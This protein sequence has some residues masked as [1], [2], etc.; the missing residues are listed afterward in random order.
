MLYEWYAGWRWEQCRRG[1]V[2]DE[3]L[4]SFETEEEC[5]ADALRRRKTRP[6]EPARDALT[7]QDDC[8]RLAA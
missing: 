8:A 3:C 4:R 7:G 2:V 1:L 6:A 5:R